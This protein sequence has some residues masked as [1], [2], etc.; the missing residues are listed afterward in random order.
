MRKLKSLI[1]RLKGGINSCFVYL[2]G[3]DG[4]ILVYIEGGVVQRRL[5]AATPDRQHTKSFIDLINEY[6]QA[7]IYMLVDTLD[8]SYV[9][10]S[11]PPVTPL[12]LGKLVQ[13]RLERDF[14][15]EDIKGALNLGREKK[16]RKDWNFLLISISPAAGLQGWLDLVLDLHNHFRGIYLLPVECEI[17]ITQLSKKLDIPSS[18]TLSEDLAEE[19]APKRRI[20]L[21]GRKVK[22][23]GEKAEFTLNAPRWQLLVTHHK[24]GGFRQ[25]VLK[26]EKLVF[27]RITQGAEAPTPAI[28][29]GNVEQEVLNTIEY[30]KR[31]SLT[32]TAALE[33][34][35]IISQEIK[36]QLTANRIPCKKA[37]ILTPYEAAELFNLK[38]AVLSADRYGDMVLATSFG[39]QKKHRLKLNPTYAD[40][41]DK[42]Y[43][44]SMALRTA[45]GLISALAAVFI[46]VNL[47]TIPSQ[48]IDLQKLHDEERAKKAEFS[49]LQSASSKMTESADEISNVVEATDLI[50]TEKFDVI[51]SIAQAATFIDESHL[52]SSFD[53]H[54]EN[55][56]E[57]DATKPL[58]S[59]INLETDVVFS[60]GRT[61]VMNEEK[62]NFIEQVKKTYP[63]Y[64]LVPEATGSDR[65]EKLEFSLEEAE[66]QSS[67][68]N[69]KQTAS[70]KISLKGPVTNAT[71]TTP[72]PTGSMMP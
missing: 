27:T 58:A 21:P 5:F 66:K 24:V 15:K 22:N 62:N 17:F 29:A 42:F 61:K 48:L 33:I 7:P 55:M 10:H 70:V 19:T 14:A 64:T 52:I 43:K 25:V 30:L 45:G 12:G 72:P 68:S 40:K 65:A 6:P 56:L 35:F 31:L 32:D 49:T 1:K 60:S 13:R 50:T 44:A 54:I 4:A 38:Q 57:E 16:G 53:W 11:L 71:T 28:T 20:S 41:L 26:D 9:K 47:F 39:L 34:Y 67:S 37:H 3:D 46:I 23:Q 18:I 2:I 51:K 59:Y 63:D 8:Q 69:R 36:D